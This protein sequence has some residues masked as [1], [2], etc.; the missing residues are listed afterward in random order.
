[1]TPLRPPSNK[2]HAIWT[3]LPDGYADLD[4]RVLNFSLVVSLRAI[5][6]NGRLGDMLELTDWPA[7]LATLDTV[8]LFVEGQQGTVQA[9]VTSN[10]PNSALWRTLFAPTT[11]DPAHRRRRSWRRRAGC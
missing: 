7:Q 11:L 6:V 2:A 1:M 5:T 10:R 8:S 9:T 3:V 4:R